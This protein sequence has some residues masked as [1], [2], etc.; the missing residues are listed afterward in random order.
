MDLSFLLVE[1]LVDH[2]AA[3]LALAALVIIPPL[4]GIS[5]GL[6]ADSCPT[7]TLSLRS[8]LSVETVKSLK[9]SAPMLVCLVL[10]VFFHSSEDI[11]IGG[12]VS[13]LVGNLLHS[14]I[15]EELI[16]RSTL[17][18]LF[19]RRYSF[20]RAAVFSGMLFGLMHLNKAFVAKTDAQFNFALLRVCV[21]CASGVI[22][23]VLYKAHRYNLWVPVIFHFVI[24]GIGFFGAS[25]SSTGMLVHLTGMLVSFAWILSEH[26]RAMSVAGAIK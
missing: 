1:P 26:Y 15:I 21:S 6:D 12:W 8:L 24:N 25:D 2:E 10:A 4:L 11:L 18:R 22:L 16:F 9:Y 7:K 13:Y 5:Y 23:A 19:E 20:L 17:L 3:Q 14:C